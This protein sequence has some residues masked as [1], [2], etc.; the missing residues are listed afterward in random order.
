[1]PVNRGIEVSAQQRLSEGG[2]VT[3]LTALIHDSV[4]V[5]IYSEGLL[6]E[7]IITAVAAKYV[8]DNYSA[9]VAGLDQK[10]LSNLLYVE[11]SKQVA[12][13][14]EPKKQKE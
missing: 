13:T 5:K 7:Q 11:I 9:I 14:F 10:A 6:L 2:A 8:E 1:M 3:M 12:S 4:Q